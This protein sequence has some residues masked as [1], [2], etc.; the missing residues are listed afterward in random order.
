MFRRPT[1]QRHGTQ[2]Q[3]RHARAAISQARDII[4]VFA[5]LVFLLWSGVLVLRAGTRYVSL[6]GTNDVANGYITWV[7]A[8]T[9]IQW[10]V[11][12]ALDTETV[13]ISNGTYYLTN[14]II[15]TNAINVFGKNGRAL[16]IINGNYPVYSTRCFWISNVNAL[17]AGFTIT[18]GSCLSS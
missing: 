12:V 8:A 14:Q 17:V 1:C 3:S 10:A 13:W 9:Q 5:A 2:S 4:R 11:D 18:N 6:Q 15:V 16:T 7:G